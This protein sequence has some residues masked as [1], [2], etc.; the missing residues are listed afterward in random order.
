MSPAQSEDLSDVI[1]CF[2]DHKFY[3]VI[4]SLE[5]IQLK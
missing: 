2:D 5:I 3:F 4:L 1:F